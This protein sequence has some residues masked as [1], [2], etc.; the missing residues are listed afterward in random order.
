M[1]NIRIDIVTVWR[2][3]IPWS[4]YWLSM[5]KEFRLTGGIGAKTAHYIH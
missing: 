4:V 3:S 1:K 2:L 5:L